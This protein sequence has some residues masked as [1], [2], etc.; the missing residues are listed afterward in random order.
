MSETDGKINWFEIPAAETDRA[1]SFYG[2]LFGWTFEPFDDSGSYFMT[3][4]GA[5]FPSGQ[6]GIT[7]YFSTSDIDASI[8]KIKELGG[9]S[10]APQAIP[11]VGRYARCTDTEG[12][13]FGLFQRDQA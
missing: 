4:S 8:A 6:K 2:G 5:V 7:V 13:A 12:N 9:S 11:P 10:D 1:Q 3:D